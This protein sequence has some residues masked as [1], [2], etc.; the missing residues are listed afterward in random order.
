M[1]ID[2]GPR[3][4][5]KTT[6]IIEWLKEAPDRLMITFSHQ[7]ALRLKQEYRDEAPR[8]MC[9]DCYL[10]RRKQGTP[11]IKEVSIDNVDIIIE[12]MVGKKVRVVSITNDFNGVI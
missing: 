9:W 8:I 4:C 5:G 10:Q 12:Q 6:R 3:A 11:H 7:E 1:L 2:F